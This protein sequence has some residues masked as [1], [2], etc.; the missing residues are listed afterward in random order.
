[1]SDASAVNAK[2]RKARDVDSNDSS[3]EDLPLKK[4]S[5]QREVSKAPYPVSKSEENPSQSLTSTLQSGP[6]DRCARKNREC[7]QSRATI[8]RG[9][10]VC[11]QCNHAK[12]GCSHSLF[13]GRKP[14]SRAK[15]VKPKGGKKDKGKGKERATTSRASTMKRESQ[16]PSQASIPGTSPSPSLS[17]SPGPGPEPGYIP[18][19][20]S[21]RKTFPFTGDDKRELADLRKSWMALKEDHDQLIAENRQLWR[22]EDEVRHELGTLRNVVQQMRNSTFQPHTSEPPALQFPNFRQENPEWSGLLRGGAEH[23]SE[24]DYVS[25]AQTVS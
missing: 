1:M 15:S 21:S 9:S 5:R 11:D 8:Q 14:T 4:K 20:T 23:K 18:P 13:S 16:A 2:K 25:N 19:R 17:R 24:V 3:E 7:R 22:R 6:C 12:T 10:Y